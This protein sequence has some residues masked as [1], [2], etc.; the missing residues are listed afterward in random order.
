M[1]NGLGVGGAYPPL[2]GSDYL[3]NTPQVIDLVLFGVKGKMTVNGKPYN[4]Q[5]PSPEL[6]D[7]EATQVL[8][9]IFTT[10]GNSEKLVTLTQIQTARDLKTKKVK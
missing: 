2:A 9:Y 8:N 7:E 5:M 4:L 3:K 1:Q 10:W 6:T